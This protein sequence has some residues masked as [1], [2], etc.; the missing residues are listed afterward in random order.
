MV[1]AQHQG[2]GVGKAALAQV[3]D[4]V[5][6]KRVSS[7]LITSY[8]PG[9]GCPEPFYLRFGFKPTG[10]IDDGEIVLELSLT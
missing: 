9:S 5:R 1:D 7:S 2:R 4:H 8:V 3:I 6:S 10:E